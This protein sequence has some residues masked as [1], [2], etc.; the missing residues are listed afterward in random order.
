MG[1]FFNK[2]FLEMAKLPSQRT[3]DGRLKGK[4]FEQERREWNESLDSTKEA[5]VGSA[6]ANGGNEG[7][8]ELNVL[9]AEDRPKRAR[10]NRKS[11]SR[12]TRSDK[13]VRRTVLSK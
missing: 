8:P 12:K 7:Q 2:H 11:K 13:G 1:K 5:E 3:P 10:R 6:P 4:S 9:P